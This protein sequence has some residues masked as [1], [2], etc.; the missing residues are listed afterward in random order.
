[1]VQ[2]GADFASCFNI[3]KLRG[4][5]CHE[6]VNPFRVLTDVSYIHVF[7]VKKLIKEKNDGAG[8]SEYTDIN[9]ELQEVS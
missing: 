1:V 5:H 4:N 2:R 9:K 3:Y 7:Q 8:I 6:M